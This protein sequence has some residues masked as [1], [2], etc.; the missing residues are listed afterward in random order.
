VLFKAAKD[1]PDAI[2]FLWLWASMLVITL[3]LLKYENLISLE[4][5]IFDLFLCVT[6]FISYQFHIEKVNISHEETRLALSESNRRADEERRVLTRTLHDEVNPHLILTRNILQ[7]MT[8][9]LTDNE[10]ATALLAQCSEM[11][12]EAYTITRDI[13]K[14][15]HI[16]VIDSIGF[17]SALESLVSNYE[18]I[19]QN[20][21]ISIKHNLPKYPNISEE[22]SINTYKIIREALFNSIKYSKANFVTVF[23]NYNEVLQHYKIKITDDGIGIPIIANN[24]NS[25]GIGLIEIRERVRVLGGIIEIKQVTP[26]NLL[27]PGTEINFSFSV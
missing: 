17:T 2:C 16:E 7:R 11:L 20:Q 19:T 12:D 23:I 25:S 9:L 15:T 27:R 1:D 14:N 22:V 8:D 13:I 3:P 5:A 4:L 18:K 24:M 6:L 21:K 26:S 10:Q